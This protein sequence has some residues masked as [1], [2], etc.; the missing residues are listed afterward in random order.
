MVLTLPQNAP[1]LS[2]VRVLL[3]AL[4]DSG[5]GGHAVMFLG[6]RSLWCFRICA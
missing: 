1:C 3:L 6:L 2:S 4:I 5:N